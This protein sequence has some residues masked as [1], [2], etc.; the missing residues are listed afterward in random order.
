MLSFSHS[1]NPCGSS[2]DTKNDNNINIEKIKNTVPK[3]PNEILSTQINWKNDIFSESRL[4]NPVKTL[5]SQLH[6]NGN[7]IR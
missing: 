6:T 2:E 5:D 3:I 7:I 4:S 1:V